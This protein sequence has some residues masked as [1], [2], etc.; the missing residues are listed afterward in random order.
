MSGPYAHLVAEIAA[1]VP[2]L[3]Q[4]G[5]HEIR[6]LIDAR[7]AEIS[8]RPRKRDVRVALEA[9]CRAQANVRFAELGSTTRF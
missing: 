2:P 1:Y 5:F 4:D 6:Q 7:L 3:D 9:L 8:V